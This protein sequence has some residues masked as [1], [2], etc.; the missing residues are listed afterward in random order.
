MPSQTE[1]DL[2]ANLSKEIIEELTTIAV[3]RGV[4][5]GELVKSA[6]E[7][8]VDDVGVKPPE[9]DEIIQ[10]LRK[11]RRK[12]NEFNVVQLSLV[13]SVARGCAKRGSDIDLVAKFHG[14]MGLSKIGG[15]RKLAKSTIG[16]EFKID[17]L[18]IGSLKSHVYESAMNDA[19]C[20]F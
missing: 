1:L 7:N 2:N 13:G 11:V 10:K 5:L 14:S 6:V 18:P 9:A 4:Q 3:E 8:F 12:F 16:E 17:L 19:I 20:I 15:A